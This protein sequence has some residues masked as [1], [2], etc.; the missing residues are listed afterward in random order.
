[1][2][3]NLEQHP[4]TADS[5]NP[6]RLSATY[7][8]EP[9]R[10][11]RVDVG[12][13]PGGRHEYMRLPTGKVIEDLHHW[14]THPIDT[15]VSKMAPLPK[16]VGEAAMNNKGFGRPVYDPN[17]N[18]LHIAMDIATHLVE[19][20]V[21]MDTIRT[22]DDVAHGVGTPVDKDKI[23]GNLSGF[24]ISQGHPGGPQAA[25]AQETAD[26]IKAS[27]AYVLDGVRRDIKY[28]DLDTAR[29]KLTGIGLT[30]AEA[31]AIIRRYSAAP[32]SGMS[33]G[34][35]V[36]FARHANDQERQQMEQVG[37]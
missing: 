7:H 16:A 4:L 34:A 31:S 17:D 29:S 2:W 28:G 33:R 37:D 5:Y 25:V 20:Q 35:R 13:Q 22:A 30:P 36:N 6:Y 24:S 3:H 1:M 8:N 27:K 12:T 19:S 10:Q 11:D 14:G 21:P 15:F 32:R 23:E 18:M 26:R 9:G